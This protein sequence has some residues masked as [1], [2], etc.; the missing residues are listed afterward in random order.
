MTTNPHIIEATPELERRVME[1]RRKGR[2]YITRDEAEQIMRG[3][4]V[5]RTDELRYDAWELLD[6]KIRNGC[7][8]HCGTRGAHYCP[9]DVA[10]G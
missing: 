9:N 5:S 6:K 7:R 1:D 10:V 3:L 4:A 8:R 2:I